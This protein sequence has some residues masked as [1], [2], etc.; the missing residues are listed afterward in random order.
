MSSSCG[1][2]PGARAGSRRTAGDPR[3]TAAAAAWGRGSKRRALVDVLRKHAGKVCAGELVPLF[4]VAQPTLDEP[5]AW[6][7]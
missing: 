3:P 1:E 2:K 5:A 4:D 6:L 7:R